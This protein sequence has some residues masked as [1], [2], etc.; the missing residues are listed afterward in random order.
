MEFK[1]SDH[2]DTLQQTTSELKY[3]F[4]NIK[5]FYLKYVV[6]ILFAVYYDSTCFEYVVIFP[7]GF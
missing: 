4:S 6:G 1:V 5:N 2:T 7:F 3:V